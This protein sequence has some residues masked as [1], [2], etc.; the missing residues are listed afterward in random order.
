MK[1]R[2]DDN[3]FTLAPVNPECS[4]VPL[5]LVNGLFLY[6]HLARQLG[7]NQP[8]YGIYIEEEMEPERIKAHLQTRLPVDSIESLAE[9]YLDKIRAIQPNGPYRLGGECFGGV[10]AFEVARQLVEQGEDVALLV[11][12]DANVPGTLRQ[13][14]LR[15]SCH[16]LKLIAR[17]GWPYIRKLAPRVRGTAIRMAESIYSTIVQR[18]GI[19]TTGPAR[20]RVYRTYTPQPLACRVVLFKDRHND[21]WGVDQPDDLGWGEYVEE[22]VIVHELDGGHMGMLKPPCVQELAGK[23]KTY[24]ADSTPDDSLQA[25]SSAKSSLH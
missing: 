10:V 17:D 12:L 1:S 24:L 6:L 8:V 22:G 4:A 2:P 15:R 13:S 7:P 23:L 25:E 3:H 20:G 16:H 11:L 21:W 9:R 18:L 19:S 5:F 14:W